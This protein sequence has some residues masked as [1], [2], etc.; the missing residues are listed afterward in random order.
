MNYAASLQEKIGG[1][2]YFGDR[3]WTYVDRRTGINL[4]AILEKVAD[5]NSPQTV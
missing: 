4:K 2:Y 1:Q 3:A 5:E